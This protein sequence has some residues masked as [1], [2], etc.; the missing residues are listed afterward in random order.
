MVLL[1]AST[2]DF[3]LV[4]LEREEVAADEEARR[5]LASKRERSKVALGLLGSRFQRVEVD[6]AGQ[7]RV[8]DIPSNGT[9]R[10][11]VAAPPLIS[12]RGDGESAVADKD[13]NWTKR[14]LRFFPDM[15]AG[16]LTSRPDLEKLARDRAK[17]NRFGGYSDSGAAI[18][19]QIG[20]RL[21]DYSL[22]QD[23]AGLQA[24][25]SM[26]EVQPC[27]CHHLLPPSPGACPGSWLRYK[28]SG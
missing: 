23:S 8:A 22:L 16:K 4:D 9:P 25:H 12:P 11:A 18:D 28:L 21:G 6:A 10:A 5:A 26:A 2:E 19:A 7:K 15:D 3:R 14:S 17:K 27:W 24:Q 1:E 13:G 20:G